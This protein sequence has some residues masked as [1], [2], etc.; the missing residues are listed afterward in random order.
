MSADKVPKD[1][2]NEV[3]EDLLNEVP[4]DPLNEVP[5]DPLNKV[6]KDRLNEL[7]KLVEEQQKKAKENGWEVVPYA[8]YFEEAEYLD[9]PYKEKG[10]EKLRYFLWEFRRR[11]KYIRR[12]PAMNKREFCILCCYASDR[13]YEKNKDTTLIGW[14][15][16]DAVDGLYYD[17]D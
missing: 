16:W 7:K 2:L 6:P 17:R 9:F 3:P 8:K 10:P 11:D 5:E 13:V 4:E 14:C 12:N 1:P 15:A